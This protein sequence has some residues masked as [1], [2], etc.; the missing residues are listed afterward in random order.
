M[1]KHNAVPVRLNVEFAVEAQTIRAWHYPARN[2][3]LAGPDGA[4]AVILAH[5]FSLTKDCGL[6]AYARNFSKAGVHA[7]VFDYR[8]WGESDGEIRDVVLMRSQLA[9]YH[10]VLAGVREMAGID[11]ARVALWGTSY[12]GGTVV[13]CAAEDGAVAAVVAQVPNLDNLATARFLSTRIRP[14]RLMRL[15]LRLARDVVAGWRGKEPVYVQSMG[16]TGEMAAYVSDE[17][18]DEFAQVA[19][20]MWN[21]RVGLRD[22]VRLPMWRPVKKLNEL[23]CRIQLHACV[24]DDLTPWRPAVKA[25]RQLGAQAELHEYSAGHF[26]IY[27]GED[28][29]RALTTQAAFLTRELAISDSTISTS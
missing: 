1:S 17:S 22:F 3:D 26:G 8:G 28:Q 29:A 20:P 15:G 4:P 14:L 18:W 24:Q 12:S 19:G 27:V 16:R 11:P 23:P 25:A 9:D 2:D 6:E 13:A 7:V 5:G 10:A 21:N